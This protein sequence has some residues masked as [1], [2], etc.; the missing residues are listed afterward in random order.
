MKRTVLASNWLVTSGIGRIVFSWKYWTYLST[1]SHSYSSGSLVFF[2]HGIT[3]SGQGLS[4]WAGSINEQS[5]GSCS[6]VREPGSEGQLTQ[7]RHTGDKLSSLSFMGPFKRVLPLSIFG[8]KFIRGRGMAFISF[9]SPSM[10]TSAAAESYE[11]FLSH[12]QSNEHFH[13]HFGKM[14][15]KC[16][17]LTFGR[18]V[19]A[20]NQ[21]TTRNE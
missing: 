11:S 18:R 2:F 9:W 3:S 16:L 15:G 8:F 7:K 14:P 1:L 10:V 5:L 4:L 20:T 6:C 12:E 17:N 19:N 13:K 21:N